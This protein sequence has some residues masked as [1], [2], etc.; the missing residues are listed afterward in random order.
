MKSTKLFGLL[1]ILSLT[2]FAGCKDDVVNGNDVSLTVTTPTLTFGA[3]GAAQTLRFECNTSWTLTPGDQWL[4]LQYTQGEGNGIVSVTAEPY[5]NVSE[6]RTSTIEINASG[7][8]KTVEVIQSAAEIAFG[9]TQQTIAA[10]AD[11]GNLDLPFV[12][13]VAYEIDPGVDWVHV[14]TE[15]TATTVRVTVDPNTDGEDREGYVYAYRK[16]IVDQTGSKILITQTFTTDSYATD[17]VALQALYEATGGDSWTNPWDFD[18]DPTTAA[19]VTWEEIGGEMR[20]TELRLWENGMTGTLPTT[21][22]AYLKELTMFHISGNQIGGPIPEQFKY[23][24]KLTL[25]SFADNN[26]TGTIPS[27]IGAL[28]ELATFYLNGNKLEGEI[29]YDILANEN[30]PAWK[31]AGFRN[32]QSGFGFTNGDDPVSVADLEKQ[33][34]VAFYNAAGGASWTN[35]WDLDA[36]PTTWHGLYF[37]KDADDIDRVLDIHLWGNNLT[38][39]LI[40]EISQLEYCR[41]IHL[42]QNSLTGSLPASLAGMPNLEMLAVPDNSMSGDIPADY[43]NCTILKFWINN[44]NFTGDATPFKSN[45]N[46]SVWDFKGNSF[47]NL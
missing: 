19:G 41:E 20:V 9:F 33:I 13:N 3:T 32:Q 15:S 14:T 10:P 47:T 7:T 16:D 1:A 22:L 18:A 26:L 43:V 28:P 21:E 36:D 24:T 44:N 8:V 30:W 12:S 25:I 46:W 35:K 11:G 6:P 4:T 5:T 29:P 2:L 17:L 45:P 23:L 40:G 38:G 31:S 27:G 34:L 39:T 42:G 37:I